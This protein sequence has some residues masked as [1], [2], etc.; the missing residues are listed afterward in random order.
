MSL[1]EEEHQFGLVDVTDFRQRLEQGG[2]HPHQEGGEKDRTGG[3]IAELQQRNTALTAV[4]GQQVVG[5][6][7][8]LAEKR[9]A[10]FA[11]Q[12]DQ[13]AQNHPRR[14]GRHT[15]KRFQLGLTLVAGEVA[16]HLAQVGK[17]E[18]FELWS[19]PT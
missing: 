14:L 19:S 3:L 7:L 4:D 1:V 16:D 12:I 11:F 6:E 5:V 8:R 18:Q 9:V 2:Q 13:R 17:V 10:A 15:A